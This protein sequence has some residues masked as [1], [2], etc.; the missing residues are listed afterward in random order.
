MLEIKLLNCPLC[1]L[2]FFPC[3]EGRGS[4]LF[5]RCLVEVPYARHAAARGTRTPRSAAGWAGRGWGTVAARRDVEP[6]GRRGS[7]RGG[8]EAGVAQSDALP[9]GSWRRNGSG[10]AAA[11]GGR[12][13]GIGRGRAGPGGGSRGKGGLEQRGAGLAASLIPAA[14]VPRRRSIV[15]DVFHLRVDLQRLQQRAAVPG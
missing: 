14:A 3:P 15:S 2:C 6:Q 5:R 10:V 1:V 13:A 8:P 9:A 7:Q 11:G 4:S 12:R